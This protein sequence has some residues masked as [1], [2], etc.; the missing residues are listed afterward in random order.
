MTTSNTY[1]R[2]SSLISDDDADV[3]PPRTRPRRRYLED[4]LPLPTSNYYAIYPS[5]RSSLS[6]MTPIPLPRRRTTMKNNDED[7]EEI[8]CDLCNLLEHRRPPPPPIKARRVHLLLAKNESVDRLTSIHH[9]SELK[10]KRKIPRWM[11]R[12]GFLRRVARDYFCI[13]IP[14]IN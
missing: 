11:S 4:P 5:A 6:P 9:Y 7:D 3:V 1:C 8:V 12:K 10:A 13:P 14:L 2:L